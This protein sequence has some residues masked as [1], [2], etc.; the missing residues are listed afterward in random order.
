MAIVGALA[1]VEAGVLAESRAAI[2]K[3]AGVTTF[4]LDDPGRIGLIIE[5]E[6]IDQAHHVMTVQIPAVPGVLGAWPVFAST[7]DEITEPT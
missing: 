4:S 6:S 5:A 2:E 7:E 1:R 3:I